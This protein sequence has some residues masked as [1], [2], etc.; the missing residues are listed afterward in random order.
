MRVLSQCPPK[1]KDQLFTDDVSQRTADSAV[2][3]RY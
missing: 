2:R 1:R 3:D